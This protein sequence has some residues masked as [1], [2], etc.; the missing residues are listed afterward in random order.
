MFDTALNLWLQSR[1][2]PELTTVMSLVSLIGSFPGSVA[3][4]SVWAFGWR[5]PDG[6]RLLLMLAFAAVLATAVKASVGAPRPDLVDARVQT[7]GGIQG[8]G[9]DDARIRAMEDP[10]GFPS[11]H[12]AAA[13]TLT[14]G[15]ARL[16]GWRWLVAAGC[17]WI[18]L[19][20]L[21]RLYLG[22]HFPG[23]VLGGLGLGLAVVLL[24]APIGRALPAASDRRFERWGPMLAAAALGLAMLALATH[25]VRAIDAAR[26]MGFGAAA[27]VL[28]R[29]DALWAVPSWPRRLLRILLSLV[30]AGLTVDWSVWLSGLAAG[31]FLDRAVWLAGA[32]MLHAALVLAPV[33]T[34]PAASGAPRVNP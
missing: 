28:L 19:T 2:T 23:D 12:T 34:V 15:G 18:P 27:A 5:L 1:A 14:L 17:L 32:V 9:Y 29:R 8:V 22:R 21:S 6:V 10:L 16:F 4:V 3:I 30:M 7:L 25:V 31:D 26:L 13:V 11:G 33:F 24:S 20:A